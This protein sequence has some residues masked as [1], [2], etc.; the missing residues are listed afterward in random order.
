MWLDRSRGTRCRAA[1]R[2]LAVLFVALTLGALLVMPPT[3]AQAQ[4]FGSES[5]FVA[6]S[7]GPIVAPNGG[8]PEAGGSP[9]GQVRALWVDSYRDG[10]KSP[11]QVDR[12][13]ADARR[14]NV[15]T[16]LIQV[17]RA[18][19]ALY[20]RSGEPRVE[21]PTIAPDFDPLAYLITRAHAGE[22]RLDVHAWINTLPIWGMQERRPVDPR[23]VL[24]QHGPDAPGREDWL[25]RRE[26][27]AAYAGGYFLDP[28][29]P[30]AA[31][32]T[33]DV[34]LNLV[35]EYDIDGI[36][37]DYIRYPEHTDELSWGYNQTSI[38]RFNARYGKQGRPAA[39][40]PDWAQ[41][42]RD[43]VTA[44]VRQIYL[45]TLGIKPT[46]KVSAAVIPWGDG[47]RTD[48]DW[49]RMAAYSVVYQDWRAWL[50][51]GIVDIVMPMNYFREDRPPQPDW[52]DRWVAWQRDHA[53]GRQ[54]V[55]GVAIYLNDP[56]ASVAQIRRALA[57]GPDG[58]R[59]AGVALFSYAVARSGTGN[60][61]TPPDEAAEVW[62]ALT[63]PGPANDSQPPFAVRAAPP[64][65]AWRASPSGR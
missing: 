24:N 34:A 33:V 41:W 17:R 47:P 29:H 55:P 61:P 35:R 18:G 58:S 48:A 21:D 31:R 6:P 14:A 36:H 53:Y 42:R 57:P 7:G 11:A 13:L 20:L 1:A 64:A 54:I 25:T 15:N 27:G 28:G 50:E 26:D 60:E 63:E 59:V 38:D 51:E 30:D 10:F 5:P 62:A 4:L 39:T 43:Q 49:R 44:L 65:M 22:P 16:L 32:Y 19:T 8:G 46:V 56:A 3:P 40:D 2:A 52:F 45:G 9:D 23:H 12:L 37:L